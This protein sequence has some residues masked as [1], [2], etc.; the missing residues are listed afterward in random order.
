MPYSTRPL[1]TPLDVRR[2]VFAVFIRANGGP[3]TIAEVIRRTKSE[4]GLDLEALPG[5][6]PH[7]RISDMMRHQARYGRAKPTQRGVYAL[8]TTA[9]SRSTT[10]RCLNWQFVA[11][12]RR[13]PERYIARYRGEPWDPVTAR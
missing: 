11:E 2:A 12:R 1:P 8:D 9:F 6:R 13:A 3:L 4:S 7:Q 5:S 10:W